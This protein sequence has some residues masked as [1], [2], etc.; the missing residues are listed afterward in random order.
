MPI[1]GN[2]SQPH[3]G[4]KLAALLAGLT[5]TA[6]CTPAEDTAAAPTPD[7]APAAT[8][9]VE[10]SVGPFSRRQWRRCERSAPK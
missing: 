8:P 7:A 2:K 3:A 4:L 10:R 6:A 5:L 1:R 9:P